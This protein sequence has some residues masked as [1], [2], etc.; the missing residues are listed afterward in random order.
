MSDTKKTSFVNITFGT[1]ICEDCAKE[2]RLQFGQ[3]EHYIKSLTTEMW[4]D[5]Q[6]LAISQDI[7]GNLRFYDFLVRYNL[8]QKEFKEKYSCELAKFYKRRLAAILDGREFNEKVPFNG[9]DD[10]I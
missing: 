9:I 6:L 10:R 3:S 8:V 2:H 7:G 1:F 5:Y 4:D